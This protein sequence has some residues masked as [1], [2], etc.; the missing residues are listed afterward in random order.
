MSIAGLAPSVNGDGGDWRQQMANHCAENYDAATL[1]VTEVAKLLRISR[2][3]AYE[4][5]QRRQ[6]PHIRIGR[7]ILIPKKALDRLLNSATE[8]Y[9]D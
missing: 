2:G 5:I 9:Q 7:R 4:A 1:T 6:I 8:E 3:S